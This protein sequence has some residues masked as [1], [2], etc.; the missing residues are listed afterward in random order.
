MRTAAIPN[1]NEVMIDRGLNIYPDV[2][3][4]MEDNAAMWKHLRAF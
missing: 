3:G 2:S 1:S 4:K